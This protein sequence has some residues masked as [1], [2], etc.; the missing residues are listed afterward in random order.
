M[1]VNENKYNIPLEIDLDKADLA[2]VLKQSINKKV[3]LSGKCIFK[4]DNNIKQNVLNASILIPTEE[5]VIQPEI[6]N[7]SVVN[8]VYEQSNTDENSVIGEVYGQSG[9]EEASV[10]ND[11]YAEQSITPE[12]EV[13]VNAQPEVVVELQPQVPVEPQPEVIQPETPV[14]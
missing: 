4:T 13:V 1:L 7:I 6:N 9:D 8:E 3:T 10:V 5:V 14:S 11:T 12:F 2:L